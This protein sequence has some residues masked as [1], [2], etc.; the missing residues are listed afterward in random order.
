MN[1]KLLMVTLIIVAVELIFGFFYT[2][3]CD[4][5]FHPV[6]SYI[7]LAIGFVCG[8]FAGDHYRKYIKS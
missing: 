2:R 5:M 3:Y 7:Q 6:I 1:R 8:F 4:S